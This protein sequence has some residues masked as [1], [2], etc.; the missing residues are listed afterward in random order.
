M[1]GQDAAAKEHVTSLL[2][3]FGW[4]AARVIDLGGIAAARALEMYVPLWLGM[5][6]VFGH[7]DFNIEVRRAG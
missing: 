5:S 3:E 4:P 1:C 2:G 6:R 7:G